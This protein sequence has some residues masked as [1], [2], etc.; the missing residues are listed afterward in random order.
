MP[1]NTQSTLAPFVA[2]SKAKDSKTD[3]QK[4][5]EQSSYSSVKDY[6]TSEALPDAKIFW[7]G[8]VIANKYSLNSCRNKNELFSKMFENSSIAQS[9]VVGSTK[10]SYM[11]NF[12]LALYFK[13][14]LE[15]SPKEKVLIRCVVLTK[16]Q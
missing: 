7:V 13:S 16:V 3:N 12:G 14:L 15:E 9:F 1:S 2:A 11:I 4:E 10:C 6:F 8:D 5:S